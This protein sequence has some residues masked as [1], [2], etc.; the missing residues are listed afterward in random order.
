MSSIQELVSIN[1]RQEVIIHDLQSRINELQRQLFENTRYFRDALH[2]CE[3]ALAQ[4]QD[5]VRRVPFGSRFIVPYNS[6]IANA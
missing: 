3:Q 4:Q 1:R 6:S 2:R 5:I